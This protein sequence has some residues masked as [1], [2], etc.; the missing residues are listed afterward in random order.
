MAESVEDDIESFES[1]RLS[2]YP[3]VQALGPQL[4]EDGYANEFEDSLEDLINR[5]QAFTE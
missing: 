1:N 2:D 5:V 3:R 4:A